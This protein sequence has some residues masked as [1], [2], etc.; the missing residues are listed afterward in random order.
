LIE[1]N[2]SGNREDYSNDLTLKFPLRIS[3]KL[4]YLFKIAVKKNE[5]F[6]CIFVY[7]P[8]TDPMLNGTIYQLPILTTENMIAGILGSV[9]D[10]VLMRPQP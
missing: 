6:K 9:V 5:E 8:A 10:A 7:F 3:N 4:N 1:L 2:K